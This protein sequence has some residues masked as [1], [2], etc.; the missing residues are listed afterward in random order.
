MNIR[1]SSC[2]FIYVRL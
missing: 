2:L 1:M